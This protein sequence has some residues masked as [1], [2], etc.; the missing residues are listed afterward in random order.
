MNLKLRCL[1]L[2]LGIFGL[3][4]AAAP[5]AAAQEEPQPA[6]PEMIVVDALF[7][8]GRVL[9]GTEVVHDFL[10]ENRGSGDLAI[11]QVRTG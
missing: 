5:A 2:A 4:A 7:D 8:F 10:V 6:M 9:E 3:L 11:N 1:A